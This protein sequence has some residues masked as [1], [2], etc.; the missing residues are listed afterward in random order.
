MNIPLDHLDEVIDARILERG[1]DYF[2]SGAVGE[3]EELEQGLYEAIVEGSDDYTVRVRLKGNSV[4][5]HHCDCPYDLGPVCKHVVA[6]ILE[7]KDT[8][9]S[10]P[11]STKGAKAAKKKPTVA[12]QVDSALSTLPHDELAAFVRERCMADASFRQ[13][14]LITCAP[15]AVSGD[16][17]YHLKQIRSGLRAV[18]GRGG[19]FGWNET[20]AAAAVLDNVLEQ[21]D[22]LIKKGHAPRA[23][24][25]VTAVIEGG[26]EAMENADDSNGDIGGAITSAMELLADLAGA[27]HDEPFRMELLAGIQHMLAN[28]AIS[29]CDWN[30]LLEPAAA[31][32]VRTEAEAAPLMASLKRSAA[33]P[34][35]GSA[36]RNALLDL[37]RRFKGEAAAHA[38]EESFMVHTDV[39]ERAIE[40]A[41]KAKDWQRARQLAQDGKLVMH[42]GGPATHAHYWTPYLLRIA[43]LTKDIPEV[44]RLARALVVDNGNNAMEQYKLLRK[45]V[46]ADEWK[47]F[48]DKLLNDLRKG[49]RGYNRHLTAS[50]CAVEERWDVVMAL[51]RDEAE[52]PYT[53]HSTLDEY[54]QKLAQLYPEEVATM[55]AERAEAYA[56]RPNPKRDDYVQATKLLRRIRKL[57]DRQLVDA[58]ATDWR[59]RLARRKG[60]MEELDKV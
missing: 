38:M 50:I 17:K 13:Q 24:P 9:L 20:F 42:D 36:A 22:S 43:Q 12:Q 8:V 23:L 59:A 30:G 60:L 53:Y 6:L 4:I 33:K 1:Q 26:A 51:A 55:L 14:F 58:L 18:A 41:I 28:E 56:S 40:A 10:R 37:T 19:Y 48:V 21:A 54:E 7:L 52:N 34:H 27:S 32:L 57:G 5:E 2:G 11:A 49:A 45:H 3:P 46:P 31:A 29:D 44:V 15:Q 39:R 25:M 47:P 35:Y 16:R